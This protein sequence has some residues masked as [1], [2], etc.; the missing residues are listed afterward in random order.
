MAEFESIFVDRGQFL[1][2]EAATQWTPSPEKEPCVELRA[3]KDTREVIWLNHL[4][5]L[6][7][8]KGYQIQ[9]TEGDGDCSGYAIAMGMA[10]IAHERGYKAYPSIQEVIDFLETDLTLASHWA[11]LDNPDHNAKILEQLREDKAEVEELFGAHTPHGLYSPLQL[12]LVTRWFSRVYAK[13]NV[14][15]VVVQQK[16]PTSL[17]MDIEPG[18]E[19]EL[20]M[21]L[22]DPLPDDVLMFIHGDPWHASGIIPTD[23]LLSTGFQ[24]EMTDRAK[25][26][27]GSLEAKDVWTYG[28]RELFDRRASLG[29][30]G[31]RY[32]D[33]DEDEIID[34][35]RGWEPKKDRSRWPFG[36]RSFVRW[37]DRA[38]FRLQTYRSNLFLAH[39][40]YQMAL[41]LLVGQRKRINAAR[42]KV[43]EDRMLAGQHLDECDEC[44]VEAETLEESR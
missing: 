15:L 43:E 41:L 9:A 29:D 27:L 12:A 10:N 30:H 34:S 4:R 8:N 2:S 39:R 40:P 24:K 44:Y 3:K 6:I 38:M 33:A 35:R 23:T 26:W 32:I 36:T 20:Q 19:G 17:V 21:I 18:L 22:E 42:E 31:P 5:D 25:N 14:R 37:V 7:A 28:K 13:E 16:D 11:T 1:I